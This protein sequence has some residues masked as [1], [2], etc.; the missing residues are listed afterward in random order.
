MADTD[1]V[2]TGTQASVGPNDLL[3]FLLELAAL[4][5]LCWWGFATGSGVPAVALGVGAPVAAAV[6]W[7]LF[8][9]PRARRPLSRGGT[10]A[11][12]A[13]VFGSAAA[14]VAAIGHPVLAGVFAV[15]VVVNLTVADR[16]RRD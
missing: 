13:L 1:A 11:V 10:L 15:V 16:H 2:T 9:A 6:V 12:K 5:G 3:A 7:G 8:A 4:A 14:A